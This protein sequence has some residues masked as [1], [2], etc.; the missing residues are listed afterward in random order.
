MVYE[1]LLQ[2]QIQITQDAKAK[3]T[4]ARGIVIFRMEQ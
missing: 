2:I 4:D 3:I 1:V